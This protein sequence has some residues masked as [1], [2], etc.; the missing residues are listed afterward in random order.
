LQR[1]WCSLLLLLAL[2]VTLHPLSA[3]I[4]AVDIT[5]NISVP[6]DWTYTITN[7]QAAGSPDYISE[8]DV[9]ISAPIQV[10]A[11]PTGWTYQIGVC[12]GVTCIQFGS[13]DS[14]DDLA[15][16][17]TLSGFTISSPGAVDVLA[18]AVAYSW[19]H[20]TDQPGPDSVAFSVDSPSDPVPEPWTG[21]TVGLALLVGSMW[22]RK[23]SRRAG[24]GAPVAR[25]TAF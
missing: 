20:N 13:L 5:S 23:K 11:L 3:S 1:I 7:E 6:G 9:A 19:D 25:L 18:N 17:G 10:T 16:G 4:L 22:L 21:S 14:S 12:Q 2:T 15:P 24:I 8:F